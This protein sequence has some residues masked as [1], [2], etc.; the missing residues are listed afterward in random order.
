M[1]VLG[2]DPGVPASPVR[3]RF[4]LSAVV[5]RQ[6]QQTQTGAP[7][8]G[9]Q[10]HHAR[11]P[12]VRARWGDVVNRRVIVQHLPTPGFTE[13]CCPLGNGMGTGRDAARGRRDPAGAAREERQPGD[14]GDNQ[15]G[16]CHDH[17]C[18][19]GPAPRGVKKGRNIQLDGRAI[20]LGGRSRQG[21][22]ASRRAHEGLLA[23]GSARVRVRVRVTE[24]ESRRWTRRAHGCG[25][26]RGEARG[27]AR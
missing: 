13:R 7:H 9:G 18:G 24:S 10:A 22:V 5:P 27:R 26:G 4:H 23:R 3:R 15:G 6:E 21:H 1:V 8:L 20:F 19:D 2:Q 17:P 25:E 11:L 12:R 16:F 14:R